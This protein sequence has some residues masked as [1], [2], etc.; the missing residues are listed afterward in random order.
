MPLG[1]GTTLG[2][3]LLELLLLTWRQRVP[4][5]LKTVARPV[6]VGWAHRFEL[7]AHLL[8]KSAPLIGRQRSHL[9]A[10]FP[11]PHHRLF[12]RQEMVPA[13]AGAAI[14]AFGR[15]TVLVSGRRAILRA[16]RRTVRPLIGRRRSVLTLVG[17]CVLCDRNSSGAQEKAGS[18]TGQQET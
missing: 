13:S 12:R 17:G 4:L 16:G 2:N 1:A 10:V 14:L 7:R 5:G 8:M 15:R 6:L 3:P 11:Q 9:I 18:Q